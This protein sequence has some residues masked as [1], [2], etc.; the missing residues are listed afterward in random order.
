MGPTCPVQRI[1]PDPNCADKPYINVKVAVI[2]QVGKQYQ[3]QTDTA[4]NFKII[5]PA[6]TYTVK[7]ISVNILPRCEQK[8]VEVAANKFASV[9]ISCDTG[10]R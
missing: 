10:I 6:G 5:A 2:N 8:Q 3:G 7:V 1:P 9:D 4:G